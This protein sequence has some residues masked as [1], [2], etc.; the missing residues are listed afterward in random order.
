M[1][2]KKHNIYTDFKV[3]KLYAE[4]VQLYSKLGVKS[5]LST[6]ILYVPECSFLLLPSFY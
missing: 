5:L 2:A 6:T 3:P 1:G 4:R